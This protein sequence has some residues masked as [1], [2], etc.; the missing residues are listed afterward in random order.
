MRLTRR[1]AI[2][3]GLASL[4]TPAFAEIRVKP[5]KGSDQTNALQN[6]IDQ[7]SAAGKE[8][9]M[10][11]GRYRVAGLHIV[12]PLSMRGAPGLTRIE[13]IS[14]DPIITAIDTESVSIT[15]VVLSGGDGN[16]PLLGGTRVKGLRIENCILK[17]G[18]RGIAL[19]ACAGQIINNTVSGQGDIGIFALDSSGLEISGNT[20]SEIGN[21]G[22]QIFRST[23]AEDGTLITNNRVS[24]INNRDGGSGQYGNGISV[25]R[26][27]NVIVSNN[28]ITDCAY[29]GI[30]SNSG[31]N[32]QMIGNSVSRCQEVALYSEFEF[33]G[34]IISNNFVEEAAYGVSVANYDVD[35]RMAVVSGNL[36]RKIRL[37]KGFPPN[38]V[39][40][41][42]CEADSIVSNNI[43]EDVSD[44]GIRLG[45]GKCRNVI[46]EGNIVRFAKY[47]IVVSAAPGAESISVAN[48]TIVAEVAIIAM[49]HHI[50]VTGDLLLDSS[51]TPLHVTLT[52]NRVG[53]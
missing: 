41:I 51:A 37:G 18:K 48:N 49:D 52:G 35:G 2:A 27:G 53:T 14:T 20:V 39:F 33:R 28:R 29:T 42:Q 31:S 43:I 25:F 46:A 23:F 10:E 22:I 4:A 36:I 19:E 45:W 26:A 17:S 16:D 50:P 9:V 38:P 11:G 15:G 30:R 12:K 47:G 5:S 3:A 13:S 1:A 32:I 21:N 8:L 7:A 24:N 6:A 44:W 40:G 34:A